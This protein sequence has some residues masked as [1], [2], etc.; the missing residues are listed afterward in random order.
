MGC[1]FSPSSFQV[2]FFVLFICVGLFFWWDWGFMLAG[3]L[4]FW[5]GYFGDGGLSNYLPS[6]ASNHN[7]P[8]LSPSGSQDYSHGPLVPG[9]SVLEAKKTE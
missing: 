6:L 5:S 3:A 9:S 8:N 7:P 4:P 2:L 1:S